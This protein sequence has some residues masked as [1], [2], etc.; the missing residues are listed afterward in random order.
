MRVLTIEERPSG[1]LY[2]QI[3]EFNKEGQ[4]K[5]CEYGFVDNYSIATRLPIQQTDKESK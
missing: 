1:Q 4:F 3:K 2:Y 5:I